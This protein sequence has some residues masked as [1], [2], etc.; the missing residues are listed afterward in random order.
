MRWLDGIINSMEMSLSKLQEIVKDREGIAAAPGDGELPSLAQWGLGP[1]AGTTALRELSLRGSRRQEGDLGLGRLLGAPEHALC[2][3]GPMLGPVFCPGILG[4]PS[5]CERV[6]GS[7]GG[8][9]ILDR[10]GHARP[11]LSLETVA[12]WFQALEGGGQSHL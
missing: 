5:G 3:P 10:P 6:G 2:F 1:R 9:C 4:T 7:A 11:S 12:A 8:N